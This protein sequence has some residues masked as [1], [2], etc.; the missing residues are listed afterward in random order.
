M[1][2]ISTVFCIFSYA[3][4]LKVPLSSLANHFQFNSNNA[5][6]PTNDKI[7]E[8]AKFATEKGGLTAPIQL[9]QS[10]MTVLI[11]TGS[12]NLW[13]P[14]N[15]CRNNIMVLSDCGPG[16]DN[17]TS[18]PVDTSLIFNSTRFN[19]FTGIQYLRYG[20]QSI[21]DGQLQNDILTFGGQPT[22]YVNFEEVIKEYGV[23]EVGDPNP[24]MNT[25]TQAGGFNGIGIW[26]LGF[27][28]NNA[29]GFNTVIETL[30]MKKA[31]PEYLFGISLGN[32]QDDDVNGQLSLGEIDN[33]KFTGEL[34]YTPVDP[35]PSSLAGRFND[36]WRIK[37]SSFK[38]GDIDVTSILDTENFDDRV[39]IDSGNSNIKLPSA[40]YL[41][42][43]NIFGATMSVI[44]NCSDNIIDNY[45]SLTLTFGNQD[46]TLPS[47]FFV[48][49]NSV[50]TSSCRLLFTD[51]GSARPQRF[52]LGA[53]FLKKYYSVFDFANKRIGLATAINAGDAVVPA[54]TT[55]TTKKTS[56]TSTTT[57]NEKSDSTLSQKLNLDI[58]LFIFIAY[59]Y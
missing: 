50:V 35:F 29:V 15:I 21:A 6:L 8:I 41:Q 33:T 42:L 44:S 10:T 14:G 26:G 12:S 36:E 45:P 25:I 58:L 2:Y 55:S 30:F 4:S 39:L 49:R 54:T 47:T 27:P 32:P 22:V 16:Y 53:P 23:D 59:L 24:D 38:V 56:T 40:V 1:F 17:S 19:K 20:D 43:Q 28:S 9:G 3:F 57:Q 18:K 11:D 34:I 52:T 13:V 51:G 31:I 46:F 7:I 37:L 5:N 48:K